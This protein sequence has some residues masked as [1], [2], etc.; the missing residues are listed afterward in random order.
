MGPIHIKAAPVVKELIE[1]LIVFWPGSLLF[2]L[3]LKAPGIQ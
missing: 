1:Q 3:H 2:P